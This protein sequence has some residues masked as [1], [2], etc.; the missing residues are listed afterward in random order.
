[1]PVKYQIHL[2]LARLRGG[3]RPGETETAETET[4]ETEICDA[5]VWF[6]QERRWVSRS[7]CRRLF[8]GAGSR[9]GEFSGEQR[10]AIEAIIRDYLV[11]NPDVMLEVLEAAK[12]E[13]RNDAQAQRMR[14]W[15][16][17]G[18]RSSRTRTRR[19]SAIRRAT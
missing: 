8:D 7:S 19:S 1:M 14:R 17:G 9:S 16:S 5:A 4:G 11:K 13:V 12:E 2:R 10:Q 18:R 3:E 15:R 6:S